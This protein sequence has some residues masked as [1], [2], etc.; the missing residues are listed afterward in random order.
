M[1][2]IKKLNG[3]NIKD[4]VARNGINSLTEIT[5]NNTTN[6]NNLSLNKANLLDKLVIFGDSWS[7]NTVTDSIWGAIVGEKLN[8][9]VENYAKN[10]GYMY[11]NNAIDLPSRVTDYLE[12]DSD[13][14]KVKYIIIMG[15]INDY[16]HDITLNN[17]VSSL[18]T[19]I[20]RLEENCPQAKI[21]YISNCEY[22]YDI[23]QGVYWTGVHEL[24]RINTSI[25]TLNL[26][27]IIGKGAFNTSNY[28]HLTQNGYRLLAS[29]IVSLLTGGEICCY[30]EDRFLSNSDADIRYSS[31]RIGNI[32]H[33]ILQVYCKQP[34]T[35]TTVNIESGEPNLPYGGSALGYGISW[36]YTNLIADINNDKIVIGSSIE[37]HVGDYYYLTWDINLYNPSVQN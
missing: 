33:C 3:Y 10:A 24:L 14:T 16:R 28:F 15:G 8:L 25:A 5:T 26:F 21:V 6:I 18:T 37:T 30:Q 36:R 22:P 7:D 9:T 12:S 13:K 35:T 32:I 4:E 34:F 11:G 27:N 2:D 19:Q 17:L 20:T 31:Q 23:S 1:S 29:N